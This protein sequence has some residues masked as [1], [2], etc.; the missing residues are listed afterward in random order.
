MASIHLIEKGSASGSVKAVDRETHT[1]DS[2][3]WKVTVQVAQRLVGG[4]IYLHS[5]WADLSHFGGI[6][7]SFHVFSKAGSAESGRVVFRFQARLDHKGV[8]APPGANGE[9]RIFLI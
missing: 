3:Y 9:K 6:I 7:D 2:G 1:Y 8:K 5:H 4:H